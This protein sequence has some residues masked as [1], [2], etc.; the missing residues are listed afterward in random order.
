M[1]SHISAKKST[2]PFFFLNLL[3]FL[4]VKST[5]PATNE[6]QMGTSYIVSKSRPQ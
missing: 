1:E 4:S 3:K 2:K 6:A 5:K